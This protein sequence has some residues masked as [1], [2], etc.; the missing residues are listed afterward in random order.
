MA[1]ATT[2]LHVI[3]FPAIFH[4]AL[5]CFSN[6]AKLLA[7]IEFKRYRT[8]Y[9]LIEIMGLGGHSQQLLCFHFGTVKERAKM[10]WLMTLYG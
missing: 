4:T 3:R 7:Y 1:D 5:G 8:L 6:I 2:D 10:H 9:F